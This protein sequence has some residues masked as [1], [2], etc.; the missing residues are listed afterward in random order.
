MI[1]ALAAL[2]VLHGGATPLLH[3]PDNN[4]LIDPMRPVSQITRH[5]FTLQ[6]HTATPTET[7]VQVREADVPMTAWRP[8]GPAQDLWRGARVFTTPGRSKTFHT[9]TITGLRPGTRYFYRIYDPGAKPTPVERRWGADGSWRREFAVATQAPRGQKTI[10]HLPIKVLLMPNVINVASAHDASGAIA[11]EPPRISQQEIDLI[12]REFQDSALFFWVNSG[13]RL[14][15]D[16]QFFVDERWQRWGEEPANATS[17]YRGWPASRSWPGEDFRAPGGG[18]FTIVDTRDHLRHTSEPVFEERPFAGQVEMA[19]PRRWNPKAGRWEFYTS[20]GGTYGV[21]S[22]PMGFP[23]RSQFLAGG[24]SAWL[25]AHEVHHQLESMG[26]FSLSNREDERVVF[27]H[28]EPRRRIAREDGTIHEMTWTTSSRH[29]EHWDGMAYW[30]RTLTDAQWLRFYFGYPITVRDADE[31]GF[32]DD[33]P[34]LPLDERRF[35]SDPRLRATDGRMND[36][37]KAMLSTWVPGPLQP[38]WTKPPHQAFRVDPRRMD[39]N[40]NGIPDFADPYPLYPWRPFVYPLQA[41]VDGD[42][43]EWKE[44]PLAGS[45]RVADMDLAFHHAHHEAGYYGLFTLKGPWRRV[46]VTLDGEGLGVYSGVGVKGFEIHNGNEITVRPSFVPMPGLQWKASKAGDTTY[47]EFSFP[48]RGGGNWFWSRGG[49]EIGLIINVQNETNQVFSVYEPYRP[50][51]CRMLEPH[52]QPPMPPNAPAPLGI[53]DEV[54]SLK[55][56][57]P[58]FQLG[59]GWKLD[60]SNYRHSGPEGSLSFEVPETLDFDLWAEIEARQDGI[61]GAFVRGQKEIHAG[62]DYI[63][64]VGGYGNTATRLR[65]FGREEGDEQVVM[66]PGRHT[67]QLSRRADGI[68]ALFDGKPI[69]WAP[70]PNPKVLIDRLA[71]LGGYGGNQVVHEVRYRVGGVEQGSR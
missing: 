55:P 9:V 30:D 17:F 19:W 50:F 49:R 32:P 12:K 47:V 44:Q 6:Y 10:I 18:A 20:G 62:R 26:A 58:R 40:G 33:D 8:D 59:A 68:W 57:D 7:R 37:H 21:D 15:V 14:W 24:D 35:G 27:N 34:R 67:I 51:Y 38:S 1:S 46:M 71:V 5:S 16:Y 60:G 53:G 42:P 11:P 54:V 39:N 22:W 61:L 36:L 4:P 23:S 25:A 65:L 63:L 3:Q 29:G 64:F 31:D 13:M 52:G 48:N 56:G 70:D 28:Y 43:A 41:T 2:V 69:L 45:L 66:S